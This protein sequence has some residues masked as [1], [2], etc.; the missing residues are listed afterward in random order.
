MDMNNK[1]ILTKTIHNRRMIAGLAG[2]ILLAVLYYMAA[3]NLNILESC[4]NTAVIMLEEDSLTRKEVLEF[5]QKEEEQE[6]P[7]SFTAWRQEN[8]AVIQNRDLNRSSTVSLLEI[9]GRSDILLRGSSR[10]DREEVEGCLLDEKTAG[11]IFGSTS[12]EGMPVEINGKEKII[13]GIL[14]GV[15][16]VI[17]CEAEDGVSLTTLSVVS[18]AELNYEEVQQ[19]FMMRYFLTG[20][21]L[22]M[23][24]LYRTASLLTLLIPLAGAGSILLAIGKRAWMM[25]DKKESLFYGILTVL[26]VMILIRFLIANV[27]IPRDM[28]PTKWSDFDF[29][30]IWWDRE[31]ESILLLIL[32][33]KQKTQQMYFNAFYSVVCCSVAGLF[34]LKSVT[35]IIKSNADASS[36]KTG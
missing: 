29:W 3:K 35:G 28:I 16:D 30:K 26:G 11:E 22:R 23:D 6:E 5:L 31:R 34:L 25:R 15:S 12:V 17:I 24:I 4:R 7:Y 1:G 32:T 20:K 33:E 18:S 14:Y 36:M 10:I 13:R 27:E 9:C 19:E 8:E 21:F 2:V